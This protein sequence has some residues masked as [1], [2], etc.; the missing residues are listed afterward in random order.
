MSFLL[1]IEG[2][3]GAGKATVSAAI[4]AALAA[5]GLRAEVLSFPRYTQTVG[6]HVLG[7]YLAGRLPHPVTPQAAAVLYALDRLESRDHLMTRAATC[8]VLV[9]DRYIASNMAYQ[10][11]NAG[12]TGVDALMGWIMAL[13]TGAFALPPPDLSVYLD[14]PQDV[15]RRLIL[16]K[17][18]RSYTDQAFDAYEA[19]TALQARVRRAYADMAARNL[20]GPWLTVSTVTGEASRPPAEIADDIVTVIRERLAAR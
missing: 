1:A 11:A 4:V 2:A 8:D 16:Q 14:T 18:Q 19:D 9:F 7:D 17:R 6:G 10:A 20:L 13:E 5:D 15:A 12:D 3:D